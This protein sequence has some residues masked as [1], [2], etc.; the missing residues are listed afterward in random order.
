M[1]GIS[2]LRKYCIKESKGYNPISDRCHLNKS[3]LVEDDK[4]IINTYLQEE[5][6]EGVKS[7]LAF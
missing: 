5:S 3:S 7:Y 4:S 1:G 6:Y 2:K